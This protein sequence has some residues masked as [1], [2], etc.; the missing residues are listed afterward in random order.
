MSKQ[1][2]DKAIYSF[3]QAAERGIK[4]YFNML[5]AGASLQSQMLEAF[6]PVVMMPQVYKDVGN[7]LAAASGVLAQMGKEFPKPAFGLTE[8]SIGGKPV[9]V[10]EEAVLKKDFCTLLHFKRDTKR[11]D[12]K[13]VIVA[14][15]S[16]HHATQF[17]DTIVALLPGHDVY[18]VDWKNPRDVPMDKGAFGF[19]DYVAHVED[20]IEAVGPGAHVIGVSQ[21]TVPLMAAVALLAEKNSPVQP[22]SMTLM[23]GPIDTAAARTAV[24]EFVK[25]RD[26][27][28]F[29]E[30]FIAE[31]PEGYAGAGRPVYP[32]FLQLA[33]LLAVNPLAHI[34]AYVDLFNYLAAGETGKANEIKSFYNEYLSVCDLTEKFYLDTIARVFLKQELADGAMQVN[35]QK[36]AP[37]KIAKTALMTIE[38]AND[39]IV[40]PG[41]TRAAHKLCTGLDDGL[42]YHLLQKGADHYGIFN[43]RIWREE[44]MPRLAGMIRE[45]AAK[46]GV[47]Y[48][49][50]AGTVAPDKWNSPK[51][52]KSKPPRP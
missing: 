46:Q 1:Q 44:V 32:G 38:G 23:G 12:P 40:A 51:A 47:H 50:L 5:A 28:W 11:N 22:L 8:T 42:H 36:V 45:S 49:P 10:T 3:Y 34:G 15:M 39:N 48:D 20:V 21:S 6:G 31:V 25:G 4:A 16:G 35:G 24:T 33:G 41:Q 37:E 29:K 27:S 14:A 52:R 17:R 9:N 13:V 26:I 19:D 7:R 18:I 43:G 2:P 30:N